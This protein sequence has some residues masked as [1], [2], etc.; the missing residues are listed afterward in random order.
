MSEEK[1]M[2][3]NGTGSHRPRG[4]LTVVSALAVALL[5]IGP[6][7]SH[8]VYPLLAVL[9]ALAL[10]QSRAFARVSPPP[11]VAVAL[12][13][14]ATYLAIN[15]SWAVDP[16]EAMGKVAFFWGLCAVGYVS[17]LGL[18][19]VPDEE[20]EPLCRGV[21]IG[22]AIGV[23]YLT[24]ECLL[25]F[26]LLKTIL[27]ALPS[28]RPPQ[29]HVRVGANGELVIGLYL[30]NR[31]FGTAAVLLWPV[32]AMLWVWMP[33]RRALGIGGLVA[34]GLTVAAF[35]SEHETSMLAL[36]FSAVA[37]AGLVTIQKPVKWVIIAAWLTATLLVVPIASSAY[38]H[39]LYKAS[40]IPTTGRNRIILWGVA[41]QR[42]DNA[43]LL[44]IGVGSTKELDE[45]EG[46]SAEKPAD[47][48]YPLRTGRHSHNVFMQ[49]WY[50]LGAVG[51]A[52]LAVIGLT[53]LFALD[54]LPRTIKPPAL[55]SFVAATMM[56]AFS[57]GMF[58]TWFMAVLATWAMLLLMAIE[59][60][61][62]RSGFHSSMN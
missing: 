21:L 27:A 47:H 12:F 16:V 49:T 39:G 42:I 8:G 28:L 40:W 2:S 54:R 55:A 25:R 57:W 14:F 24:A 22:F 1:P 34:L 33:R 6:R 7:T 9:P 36:I 61:R 41:A 50:E 56:A 18:P 52:L 45:K 43:P 37:F 11:A 26:P 32:L 38:S 46:P 15:A 4:W 5:I 23:V 53:T 3:R 17:W 19:H 58:Q 48:S 30:L 35:A 51:A 60:A 59:L 31:S 29:K 20:F 13:A 62:R 44:G 10:W